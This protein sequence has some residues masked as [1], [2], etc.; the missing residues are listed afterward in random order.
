MN[1]RVITRLSVVAIVVTLVSGVGRPVLTFA[2][3]STGDSTE[4][5]LRAQP[6]QIAAHASRYGLTRVRP[7]EGR[8]EVYLVRKAV[9]VQSNSLTGDVTSDAAQQLTSDVLT[10]PDVHHFEVNG[11]AR[12]AETQAIPRLNES[13][14]TILDSITNRTLTGYFGTS[15]WSQYVS[16]PAGAII[17]LAQA[18][19]LATGSGVVVAIIDTGV[20]PHH[21]VL[22]GVLVS[23][24]DFTRDIAGPASEWADLDESTAVILD[25]A[26]ASIVDPSSAVAL[27]ESTAVILD[28]ATTASVDVSQLPHAFGHGT[29]VAGL[30]HMVAPTASIMPLKA[31]KADGSSNLFDI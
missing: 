23:G 21:P 16:Q 25:S 13:T 24:Y 7:V 10:D 18:Q 19:Q 11:S 9:P 1:K 15:A 5:V 12:L 3:Q 26:T 20:D 6:G 14:A 29:M 4:F 22:Q 31:F 17:H 28:S 8:P 2:A 30:V 27:N